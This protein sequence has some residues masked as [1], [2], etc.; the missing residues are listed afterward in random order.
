MS[1]KIEEIRGQIDYFDLLKYPYDR[2]VFEL[3]NEPIVNSIFLSFDGYNNVIRSDCKLVK[4]V[5]TDTLEKESNGINLVSYSSIESHQYAQ[6]LINHSV[7]VNNRLLKIT[8]DNYLYYTN[9]LVDRIFIDFTVSEKIINILSDLDEFGQ[10]ICTNFTVT[11]FYD[12][13]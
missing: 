4:I 1:Q 3:S 12:S 7:V 11:Y 10:R 5:S 9:L 13:K 2:Y 8:R 6:T